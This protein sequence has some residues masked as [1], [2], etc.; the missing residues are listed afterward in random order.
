MYGSIRHDDTFAL[1]AVRM[2]MHM[3]WRDY[4]D[5]LIYGGWYVRDA[6]AFAVS[7]ERRRV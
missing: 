7:W 1:I 6:G 4:E 5:V 2:E 3:E